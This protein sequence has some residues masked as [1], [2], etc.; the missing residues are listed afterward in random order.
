MTDH[1]DLDPDGNFNA[2]DF[3]IL[4]EVE[5]EEKNNSPKGKSGCCLIF[6]IVGLSFSASWWGISS[7]LI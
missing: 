7:F 6:F 5:R 1:D 2:T 3:F 4:E